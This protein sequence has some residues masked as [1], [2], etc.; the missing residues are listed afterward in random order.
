MHGRQA[1]VISTSTTHHAHE[2][3]PWGGNVP[4]LD[5]GGSGPAFGS[6]GPLATERRPS[7]KASLICMVAIAGAEGRSERAN[8]GNARAG[9]RRSRSDWARNHC[10]RACSFDLRPPTWEAASSRSAQR[11]RI[12]FIINNQ[13]K[14]RSQSPQSFTQLCDHDRP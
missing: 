14:R 10:P 9:N 8:P 13:S 4:V 2:H 7:L 1:G 11:P 5:S 3:L 12:E 6:A